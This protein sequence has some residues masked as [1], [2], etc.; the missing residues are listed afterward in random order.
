MAQPKKRIIFDNYDVYSDYV[1]EA[2]A[3]LI[4]PEGEEPA[5]D[6]IYDLC[7]QYAADIWDDERTS[8]E[9]FFDKPNTTWLLMGTLGL[10][11]GNFAGGFTFEAFNEMFLKAAKDCDCWSLWDENGHFYLK[12]SHHDGTNMFEIRKVT[13]AG[14]ELLENWEYSDSE[15]PLYNYSEQELHNRIWEQYSELPHY[16]HNVYGCSETEYESETM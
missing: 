14:Q 2:T 7:N 15:D 16:A 8:L 13:E 4:T 10:W 3:G 5:I 1:E 11:N 9:S 12:C 6:E